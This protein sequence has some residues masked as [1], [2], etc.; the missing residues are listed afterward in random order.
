MSVATPAVVRPGRTTTW[1]CA[2]YGE[3]LGVRAHRGDRA[4]GRHRDEH[5]RE[6][7]A[8]GAPVVNNIEIF[9][10]AFLA[11]NSTARAMSKVK[12]NPFATNVE[13][14]YAGGRRASVK[15]R[16]SPGGCPSGGRCR[17]RGGVRR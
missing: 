4:V 5:R 16:K 3:C 8:T 12:S 14:T 15:T 2:A 10:M 11:R 1:L 9:R 17:A 7:H 13:N 6:Q